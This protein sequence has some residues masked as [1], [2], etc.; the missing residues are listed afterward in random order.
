MADPSASVETLVEEQE[1]P[2][3]KHAVDPVSYH[4]IAGT[5]SGIA[6]VL[7]GYPF[8]ITKT[9]MQIDGSK[10]GFKYK[11]PLDCFKTTLRNEGLRGLYKGTAR[12][13]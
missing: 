8:D 12:T 3:H 7:V 9:R 5:N 10:A 4:L 6:V 13:T 2:T 1:G 11:G